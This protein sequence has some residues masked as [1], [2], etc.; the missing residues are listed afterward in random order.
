MV[1]KEHGGDKGKLETFEDF[2][3]LYTEARRAELSTRK[4][5]KEQ[6]HGITSEDAPQISGI[7]EGLRRIHLRAD[8][9]ATFDSAKFIAKFEGHRDKHMTVKMAR[10]L[11][12][13]AQ[14]S[15][16]IFKVV[17]KGLQELNIGDNTNESSMVSM[18]FVGQGDDYA[19]IG[20]ITGRRL[21]CVVAG[22]AEAIDKAIAEAREKMAGDVRMNKV[23]DYIEENLEVRH[24]KG[25]PQAIVN[26]GALEQ[27]LN[28]N[29]SEIAKKLRK[30]SG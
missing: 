18:V 26:S 8:Y 20:F 3:T 28:E 25:G 11:S 23:L 10:I 2:K 15:P 13:L 7:V 30:E 14:N 5:V 4:I 24:Q 29:W 27:G 21:Q 1:W 19:I 12:D 9:D 17:L 16:A 6:E 22:D